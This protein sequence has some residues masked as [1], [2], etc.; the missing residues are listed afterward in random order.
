[1]QALEQ[2]LAVLEALLASIT[3]PEDVTRALPSA[4]AAVENPAFVTTADAV[5]HANPAG[6]A[7][8]EGEAEG[9]RRAL[10]ELW[11]EQRRPDYVSVRLRL[12]GAVEH[13]VA[14][15]RLN[16]DASG[17][18]LQ[19]LARQH[20]LSPRQRQVLAFVADGK[21]N[22]FVAGKLGCSE[23]TV[24]YHVSALLKKLVCENR[25]EMVAR[26]WKGA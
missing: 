13:L 1:M 26:F 23:G 7:L 22:K 20:A 11:A 10:S 4:L 5:V 18:R 24:E 8:L 2:L 3:A 21:S 14:I 9:V 15:R 6:V 17:R 12:R 19:E 16:T 25:A